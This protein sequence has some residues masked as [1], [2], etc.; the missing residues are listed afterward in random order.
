VQGVQ[1]ARTKFGLVTVNNKTIYVLGGKLQDASRTDVVE[2]YDA[3]T[4][5]WKISD[6]NLPKARSGFSSCIV[7]DTQ[8]FVIGGNDGNV[9]QNVDIFD[10]VT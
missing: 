9:V 2:E 5:D 10:L 1:V 8:I 7:N 3:I 4:G 6:F